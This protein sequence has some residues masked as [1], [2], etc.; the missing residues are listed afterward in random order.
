MVNQ[1]AGYPKGSK[2]TTDADGN[3]MY[4]VNL[5]NKE[6]GRDPLYIDDD[7]TKGVKIFRGKKLPADVAKKVVTE[8][9]RLLKKQQPNHY[10]KWCRGVTEA[11]LKH[12]ESD[13]VK[14]RSN[15][16][17]LDLSLYPGFRFELVDVLNTTIRGNPRT[18]IY[19][20]EQRRLSEPKKLKGSKLYNESMIIP[21][22]KNMTLEQALVDH[23]YKSL[24]AKANSKKTGNLKRRSYARAGQRRKL[25]PGE[26]AMRMT[27]GELERSCKNIWKVKDLDVI[28]KDLGLS[29]T[30]L[31][32]DKCQR[33]Q[34]YHRTRPTPK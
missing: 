17:N 19:Y 12:R 7:D 1:S 20:G 31:K 29:A 11:E 25:S 6:G 14:H 32:A 28:L 10:K 30:G 2:E 8:V 18:Y 24:K 15:P 16:D 23:H 22:R 9:C 4:R 13:L 21:I 26:R 33:L 3:R 34:Q 27:K 5:I